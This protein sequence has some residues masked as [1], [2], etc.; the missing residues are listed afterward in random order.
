MTSPVQW[1][2][3]FHQCLLHRIDANEFR[4]LSKLLLQKCPIAETALLDALLQTR[5]ESRI[6]WDPLL[7]LYIDCL[8]RTGRVR[9]STVLTSLLKYSSIHD[10]PQLSTSEGKD[11]SK[12]YTLMTDIRVIQDTMLSVSTGS[13][14]KTNAEAVAI[15]FAIIDWI[16]AVASWHN[17]HFDPGQHSSGIMSSPDVV[18]LFESLGILL[19]AL[20]GTGKGLEVLSADSHEGLKVKLGQALSAYLPLCVEVS[21]PLRN[22][23]DGLQKEF[24][25]YGERVPKSLDVPMMENMNVNAL[26]FEA[27]VM[28]GPVINSRAGL[29][30]FINAMLVGRPLVD[31]GMLINYLAN[32][33]GGHYEALVE[34]ILTAS[35][36]VLSN[37]MY[38]NESS[39]MMFVFRSFLVNKLPPFF[40]AMLASTMV[41]IPMEMCISHAL[42]RLDPNT[43]PSFSQMFEM[44]GNTVLSDVRQEFL[45][46]CASHKLIPESSIERLLGENPM[47]TLPVGYN[48]DELV[49]QINANPERAEQLINEIESMEGNAG[50]IIG[51]ITEVMH[52]LCNQKETMTL[53]N[54]C[55]SL[56]RRPQALDVV[57]I[58][59]NPKQVLQPLC[60]LLDSWHWDEDQGEYQ[61]VYDEFGSILLL[62]LAFKYRFDLRPADLGISSS[63]SFVLRLLERGSCS[64]KLD[65]LD[66]KQNKNLG[67]WIAALFIAEGISEETMSACSPQE[68][69]LLVATLFSQSLEACETGK[70]EFDTLKGGFEYLL[71]PFL[72]P[73][74]IFALTWLG[75]HIWEMEL[76]PSIPLKVL[77][78]LVNPS[79]ISGEARE[80]HRTV[81]NIAARTLEEQLKDV[82]T[83]HPSRT[84][85][86]PIL[87]S[88]EPCLSFQ[89]V[90]S[91]HRSELEGWT[92][93]SSGGL[94][95]SIRST[96]QSLVLWSTNPEVSMAPPPYTHRQL[97]AGVRMLGA[98]RVLPALI[99]ELKL[100]T[101]AGNGPLALDLAATLICAPMAETFSVEQN[102]HQPVDPNKEALPRCGILTLRDVL[103]LQHE[104]VPKISE[105]DPLRAE[106]LVRLYRRVNALLA[107]PSQVPNLDVNNIIQNMQLGGVGVGAGQ[108]ELDA[109]GAADHGVGPDDAE[110]IHRMI[111][112]A[113]AAAGL[114]SSGTGLD[115]SIDDVLNAAD[116]AVGNPEFLD[117]DM[118][119]M[120]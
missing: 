120:F 91:S 90:G 108:M 32:R 109:T 17:S 31:D 88:L 40:A 61:P 66:E 44:Q 8:C 106:V 103:A 73:S 28:D 87:D 81:L 51:A 99:E 67:S 45:F 20:S 22:R 63:D 101:E 16:H 36:D 52:N 9:T 62:V 100:Q 96:F 71:E 4:N 43:F 50:A 98:S 104:N 65:A 33:Y 77:H 41:S 39:R 113:A 27:S 54:I 60:A 64:Q 114:D 95:G 21:L 12:C 89:L 107:P 97:I 110:N 25:L 55:N 79:S 105:K 26:Q 42:S 48:K 80:I 74:L 93:H 116:M 78:S 47:Q 53:K 1:G 11:G 115:T 34:E 69:Y 57:L 111:D 24:N 37:G 56:S 58:F 15:F 84:D 76:D 2:T 29:Y 82:R 23:L 18:S 117:L 112:N 49:S 92:T 35:F 72:L 30:V 59:R 94:L 119:G 85:I 46:A 19:A 68:F 6:K 7:P 75:D 86:K 118:E 13:T 102:S 38:R 3:F 10:K 70:L 5:S 83:R 14:P